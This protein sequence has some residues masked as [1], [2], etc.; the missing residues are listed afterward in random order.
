MAKQLWWGLVVLALLAFFYRVRTILTPF[1]FAVVIAYIFY[2]LVVLFET[3]GMSR[4]RAILLVYTALGTL[5]GLTLWTVLPKLT[6]ELDDVLRQLPGH[7]KHWEKVG[8][9][10]LSIF[11]KIK[12]PDMVQDGLNVIMER[13]ELAIEGL[14]SKITELV[15]GAFTNLVSLLISPVLAF[16]LLRDHQAMRARSLQYVP[17]HYR[18]E[19]QEIMGEVNQALNGFFRGQLLVSVFVGVFIYLGLL[20][21][22]IP[23]ALFIGFI[24]G[25]FD[26]IPYFGPVLGFIPAATFALLKSPLTVVWVFILFVAANQIENGIISPK[27]IGERV[28]LHPLVVIF[29]LFVGGDLMGLVGMLLAVPVAATLRVILDHFLLRRPKSTP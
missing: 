29:A 26:I 18:G 16:Y 6:S 15:M 10:T 9:D 19:V 17:A 28:G 11:R 3:R 4:V 14:A 25:L 1:L 23:N 8:K 12:L 13:L 2:P 5:L 27:I 21:L 24:A 20:L 7:F 22:R